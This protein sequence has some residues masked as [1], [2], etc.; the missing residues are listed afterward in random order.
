MTAAELG[1]A[2]RLPAARSREELRLAQVAS[3]LLMLLDAYRLTGRLPLEVQV[4]A[5]RLRH[6]VKLAVQAEAARTATLPPAPPPAVSRDS[7]AALRAWIASQPWVQPGPVG[8]VYL[9]CFRDPTTGQHRP[10]V[11]NGCRGQYAG[12]YW[13]WTDDLIRRINQHHN[14]RWRGAGR[15]VQVA[16]AAGLTFE[17]AWCEYPATRGRERR[18]KNQGSAYRRCPLC[19]GTGGP[20]DPAAAVATIQASPLPHPRSARRR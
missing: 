15:L 11:G 12:H 19:R 14:P 5:S 7:A 8:W 13:G 1:R 20:L 17:L 4:Q 3:G 2:D 9:L 16:L 6:A 10:L 18:L